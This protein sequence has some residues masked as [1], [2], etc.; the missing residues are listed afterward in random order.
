MPTDVA[1]PAGSRPG[2]DDQTRFDILAEVLHR[3]EARFPQL[4]DFE[5]VTRLVDGAR[6]VAICAHTYPDGDAIGSELALAELIE[7]AFPGT[8]VSCLLADDDEV[9]RP[10]V[11]LPGSDRLVPASGYD[12]VPDLFFAVDL[13]LAARLNHARPVMER[14]RHVAVLDHHLSDAPFW[15]AGVVRPD[16]AAAGVLVAEYARYLHVPLSQSMAQCLMCALVTDT[17]CFQYQ[18]ANGEAF[19]VASAL[20]DAGASPSEIA[21]NVYQ[22]DRLAYL[23]L[24]AVVMGRVTTFDQGRIAYSYATTAD[25]ATAGVPLA[26]CDGLVDIVRRVEGSEI[27]LFLKEVPGGKVRG[28]LRSK[29]DI[30]ISGVARAMGGGGHRAASGFT[31]EGSIDDAF[32]KILPLLRALYAEPAV[33]GAGAAGAAVGKK[34]ALGGSAPAAGE[35]VPVE[36]APAAD[37]V[38]AADAAA[39]ETVPASGQAD[40]PDSGQA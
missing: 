33:A 40:A 25:L 19:R 21:L 39:G 31:C 2:P 6:T 16:A 5:R 20:V 18:N 27:A 37:A 23:H 38:A 29:C 32:S 34:G 13:S 4:A 28:N 10:Y 11:F 8:Q 15:E 24:S 36:A 26:E 7:R 14:A 17:G 1:G 9:P 30:D 22:S 35:S 12:E 3:V